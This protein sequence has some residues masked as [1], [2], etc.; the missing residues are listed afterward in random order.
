MTTTM[1]FRI[2]FQWLVEGND[3]CPK[4][5]L[6]LE[7]CCSLLLQWLPRANSEGMINWISFPRKSF[8]RTF[9]LLRCWQLEPKEIIQR[10][11][12]K[13]PPSNCLLP[14]NVKTEHDFT[15]TLALVF[16]MLVKNYNV[17]MRM[18]FQLVESLFPCGD[19]GPSSFSF[20]CFLIC[21][22]LVLLPNRQVKAQITLQNTQSSGVSRSLIFSLQKIL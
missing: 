5:P 13:P 17:A 4:C 6:I 22:E 11:T 15:L 7:G 10:F 14:D 20:R 12:N 16:V 8:R 19:V 1:I 21:H 2:V 3:L 9:V 18:I